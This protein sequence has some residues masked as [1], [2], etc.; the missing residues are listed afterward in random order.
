[1]KILAIDTSTTVATVALVSEEKVI[2]EMSLNDQKTHSQRLMKLIEELLNFSEVQINE[3]SGIAVGVGPGSF[4]GLRIGVTTAKALAHSAKLPVFEVSS[5]EAMAQ[6]VSEKNVVS[7]MDA[8]R[9]TVF[10]GYYNEGSFIEDQKHI[11]EVCE[12]IKE[13][14]YFVGDGALKQKERIQSQLTDKAKFVPI[15]LN[16]VRAST[17]GFLAQ[18]KEEKSYDDVHVKYLRKSQAE[19]EYEERNLCK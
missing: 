1:M 10:Y 12:L 4:T 13:E 5:L 16:T 15:H 8:R 2:C 14:T 9:D 18:E 11:D 19:R 17:I 6:N 3:L 7:M